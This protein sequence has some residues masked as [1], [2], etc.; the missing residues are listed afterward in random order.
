MDE[1]NT[2][3]DTTEQKEQKLNKADILQ[4]LSNALKIGTITSQDAARL[5][6]EMGIFGSDFTKAKPSKTERKAKR[7][8][9]QAARLA[10]KRAG[11]KGQKSPAGRSKTSGRGR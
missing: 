10:T 2:N 3:V 7:K 11:Y 5:R 1:D 4:V 8:T 9:Q 6:A